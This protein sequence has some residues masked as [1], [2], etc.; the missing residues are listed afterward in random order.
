MSCGVGK[1][2]EWERVSSRKGGIAGSGFLG[3]APRGVSHRGH[4]EVL[5]VDA[6]RT[7]RRFRAFRVIAAA[8]FLAALLGHL[9]RAD[10]KARASSAVGRH[11]L[12]TRHSSSL[13]KTSTRGPWRKFDRTFRS[14]FPCHSLKAKTS[15]SLS[16]TTVERNAEY[17]AFFF[18]TRG[19]RQAGH[20]FPRSREDP[21]SHHVSPSHDRRRHHADRG[22]RSPLAAARSDLR[23]RSCDLSCPFAPFLFA[24][25]GFFSSRRIA[26]A[27]PSG[28]A[29][30]ARPRSRA[31]PRRLPLPLVPQ[32]PSRVVG[33]GF[34]QFP[35]QR[36]FAQPLQVQP[37]TVSVRASRPVPICCPPVR[38]DD[39]LV[40]PRASARASTPRTR[41]SRAERDL[42]R[43]TRPP[44][45]DLRP[46]P[47]RSRV[48]R[49]TLETRHHPIRPRRQLCARILHL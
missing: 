11:H 47:G 1:E 22:A 4:G 6:G 32:N 28:A 49:A 9:A 17:R 48:A 3:F 36:P 16:T 46:R 10:G 29:P 7:L 5:G 19:P 40:S 21:T 18:W 30:P 15:I 13:T 41:R 25:W 12:P 35:P 39:H 24:R 45:R 26:S 8:T 37:P 2:E 14:M 43:R 42:A 31:H 44:R 23:G 34:I 38:P 27:R 33:S 20:N